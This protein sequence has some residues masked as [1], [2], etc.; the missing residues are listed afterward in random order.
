MIWS[1]TSPTLPFLAASIMPGC[2][3][4]W[5]AAAACKR[6]GASKIRARQLNEQKFAG[7]I[8][9]AEKSRP[10]LAAAFQVACPYMG[11]HPSSSDPTRGRV[12]EDALTHNRL[13]RILAP[14]PYRHASPYRPSWGFGSESGA[15][16]W[17]VKHKRKR[18]CLAHHAH[19]SAHHVLTLKRKRVKDAS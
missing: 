9:V 3:L 1:R 10:C 2:P 7:G 16:G 8:L 5:A 18:I 6:A 19:A 4:I 13:N 15:S 11:L 14:C 17:Q 12:K